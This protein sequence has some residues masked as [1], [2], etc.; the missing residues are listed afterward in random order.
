METPP[1]T[2][3][4]KANKP[5]IMGFFDS[6]VETIRFFVQKISLITIVI[7]AKAGIQWA[8]VYGPYE[9]AI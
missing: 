1:P 4:N 8:H 5:P 7:P 9:S 3:K 6:S 2:A